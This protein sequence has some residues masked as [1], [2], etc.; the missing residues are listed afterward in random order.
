M[1]S[2]LLMWLSGFILGTIFTATICWPRP[3]RKP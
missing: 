3:G 1:T 2:L